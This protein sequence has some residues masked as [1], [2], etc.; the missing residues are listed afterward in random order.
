MTRLR[1]FRTIPPVA[2]TRERQHGL[3][4]RWR[5]DPGRA[6]FVVVEG[7]DLLVA[8]FNGDNLHFDSRNARMLAASLTAGADILDRARSQHSIQPSRD[9]EVPHHHE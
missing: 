4:R 9:P 1:A 5:R 6:V 8:P 7:D 2:R 3:L